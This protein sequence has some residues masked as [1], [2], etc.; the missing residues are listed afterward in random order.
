MIIVEKAYSTT[1]T[2]VRKP[3]DLTV[4]FNFWHGQVGE[5]P[6]TPLKRAPQD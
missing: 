5:N 1:Q 4:F 3:I 2:S 6:W